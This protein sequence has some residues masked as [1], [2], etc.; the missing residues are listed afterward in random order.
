MFQRQKQCTDIVSGPVRNGIR[1]AGVTT[2]TQ[3][4]RFHLSCV[5]SRESS[6]SRL[7]RLAAWR[8][9][10]TLRTFC[11]SRAVSVRLHTDHVTTR[12]GA[13]A[14]PRRERARSHSERLRPPPRYYPASGLHFASP[15]PFATRRHV[16][17]VF[18]GTHPD[19]C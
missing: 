15:F 9:L 1:W 17:F 19:F 13:G 14:G 16:T 4:S 12:R 2:W 8:R 18:S 6:T 3:P 5:H 10:N 11:S 7:A